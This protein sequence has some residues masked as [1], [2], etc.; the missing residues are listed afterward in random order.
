MRKFSAEKKKTG[1]RDGV[2]NFRWIQIFTLQL[3]AKGKK[4]F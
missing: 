4:A 3:D 1:F 2:R